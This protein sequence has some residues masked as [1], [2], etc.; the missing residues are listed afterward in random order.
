MLS[1]LLLF[2]VESFL[3]VHF[4]QFHSPLVFHLHLVPLEVLT[5]TIV[6]FFKNTLSLGRQQRERGE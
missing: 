6:Q 3:F 5:T 1:L 2:S 4:P